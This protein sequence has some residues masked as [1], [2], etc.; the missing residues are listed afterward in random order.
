MW[1]W[2]HGWWWRPKRMTKKQIEEM[3]KN[4]GKSKI[5]NEKSNKYHEDEEKKADDILKKIQDNK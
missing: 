5:I 2:Y 1:E 4:M 3:V